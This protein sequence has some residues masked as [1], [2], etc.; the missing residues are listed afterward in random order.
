MTITSAEFI[1]S[2]GTMGRMVNEIKKN[3]DSMSTIGRMATSYKKTMDSMCSKSH[4]D[5][6]LKC[7]GEKFIS[8]FNG[9]GDLV[10]KIKHQSGWIN[11]IAIPSEIIYPANS[12]LI[13]NQ[14]FQGS[15]NY[16]L[17]RI[18]DALERLG[19]EYEDILEGDTLYDSIQY[20]LDYL[21]LLL[22]TDISDK[23]ITD[24][25]VKR[26]SSN[27]SHINISSDIENDKYL[28]AKYYDDEFG[29]PSERL[30]SAARQNKLPH[31][32][33]GGKNYYPFYRAKEIW[34]DDVTYD[35]PF[36]K[37]S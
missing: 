17:G 13:S 37:Q 5:I 25:S 16:S 7:Y 31:K 21:K 14:S 35:S 19:D 20:I 4:L 32:K 3:M 11:N 24:L 34:P 10:S 29:I 15:R 6:G 8:Q 22:D 9:L 18:D 26:L 1:N 2:F 12:K 23:P 33:N 36:E 30:R 28:P 27:Q